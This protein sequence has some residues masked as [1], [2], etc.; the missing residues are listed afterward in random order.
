LG[1]SA[2]FGRW[3]FGFFALVRNAWRICG[4]ALLPAEQNIEN[5]RFH[6]FT[7]AKILAKYPGDPEKRTFKNSNNLMKSLRFFWLALIRWKPTHL[8]PS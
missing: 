5:S 8:F 2:S 6:G 3:L 7:T 4:T 1:L